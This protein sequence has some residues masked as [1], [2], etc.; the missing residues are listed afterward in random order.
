MHEELAKAGVKDLSRAAKNLVLKHKK[1]GA[2]YHVVVRSTLEGDFA[3]ILT[4]I[5]GSGSGNLRNCDE[6]T[7]LALE[8]GRKGHINPLAVINDSEGK[9]QLVVD[10]GLAEKGNYMVVHPMENNKSI[11]MPWESFEAFFEKHGHPARVV[12]LE[13]TAPA[14]PPAAKGAKGAKKEDKKGE[15]KLGLSV[16][17]AEDF[18]RWYQEATNKK[19]GE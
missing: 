1:T 5:L 7:I 19:Y 3:K 14:A 8:A 10:A 13:N 18:P 4:K 12:D 11:S 15:T 2:V 9:V 16:K 17:K 6:E